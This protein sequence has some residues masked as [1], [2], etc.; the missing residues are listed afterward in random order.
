MLESKLLEVVPDDFQGILITIGEKQYYI[1][2]NIFYSFVIVIIL[3]ILFGIMARKVKKAN[4]REKP[5]GIVLI[6]EIIYTSINS[7]TRDAV[8]EKRIVLAPYV[9]SLATFILFSNLCGLIGFTPP[10]ADFNVTFT[11]AMITAFL[12]H[13]YAIKSKGLFKHIKSYAEPVP[14]LLPLNVLDIITTPVS[15]S[16]RLFGNI[17][18]GSLLMGL[19][20]SVT[21]YAA[22]LITPIFHGYF[23]LFA[24]GLQTLVFVLL[25]ITFIGKDEAEEAEVN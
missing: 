17:L 9:A 12:V 4:P 5:R 13:Y 6:A 20:Y 10:T 22:P 21:S 14:F 19:V 23:D 3:C 25:T 24:G 1:H 11:L 15:M 7:L 18:A 8:G 2:S 16:L